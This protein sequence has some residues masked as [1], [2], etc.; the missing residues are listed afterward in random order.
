LSSAEKEIEKL[1]VRIMQ[2]HRRDATSRRLVTIPGIGP[3]TASAISASVPDA[4]L[5]RSGRQFAAW[6]GLTP[7][8]NSSG[9]KDRLTGITKQGDG[10]L[11][12]L[13]VVGATA[14]L[15]YARK[16]NSGRRWA[17]RLRERKRPKVVAVALANKAA[18]RR[19]QDEAA[20]AGRRISRLAVAFEAGRDGLW[21][22]RW[23][24]ARG[25]EAYVIHATS[26]AV[27]RE[28]WRA[29]TDR[30]DTELLKQAFIGW[31]RGEP[32]HRSMVSIP[33]LGEEDA[34]WPRGRGA[35]AKACTSMLAP[36][37]AVRRP[38][39]VQLV[40]GNERPAGDP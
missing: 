23:L 16:S 10:Y 19:W 14:V 7:R 34:K 35:Q 39:F 4:S 26:I 37:C 12:R 9:G 5:F 15:R 38:A 1:E 31:L 8:A 21:L 27:S 13:L 17:M 36:E 2:W 11:R 30:L 3:V 22:A 25:I 18:L 32:N 6:L 40:F 24:R 29:K 20:K 33:S 28:H